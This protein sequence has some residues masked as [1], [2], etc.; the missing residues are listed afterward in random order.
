MG[1]LGYW[2]GNPGEPF[3][4][5]GGQTLGNATASFKMIPSG[6]VT[7]RTANEGVDWWL[8]L[9]PGGTQDWNSL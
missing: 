9:I 7:I 1:G 2:D 5:L 4:D 6:G 8:V 3:S